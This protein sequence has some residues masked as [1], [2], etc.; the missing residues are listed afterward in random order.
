MELSELIRELVPS[1]TI[2]FFGAGSSLPS[3]APTPQKIIDHFSQ[4]FSIES[5]GFSLSEFSEIIEKR[6]GDRRRLITEL[7]SMFNGLRPTSGLLN[8]PLYD[9]KSI[10]TTNYDNLI[11]Q[12]YQRKGRSVGVFSSNFDFGNISRVADTRLYK[13][14]GTLDKDIAFGDASRIILTESDYQQALEFREHLFNALKGDLAEA[15]LV[16]IG[17]SLSDEGIKSLIRQ[18][19]QLNTKTYAGGRISL[20]MYKRDDVRADLYRGQGISVIFAGID[21]FFAEL[22]KK[23]PGPLFDYEPTDSII[24][25]FPKI[26]PT[27]IDIKHQI[28]TGISDVSRMFNGWPASYID[29]VKSLTF[30]RSVSRKIN[31]YILSNTGICVTIVGASG[32]GKT[33]AARQSIVAMAKHGYICWEHKEDFTLDPS[34]WFSV[35]QSLEATGRNGILF[36]DEAHVHIREINELVDKIVS[37]Q[38]RCLVLVL[39]STRNQ[40][41]PR[42]KTPNVYKNG[43][44]FVLSKIEIEEIDKLLLL[45]EENQELS[46]VVEKNFSGFSKAE[47]RRR[48]IDRCES[49]MFVCMRNI[50]ASESFDNIILRE[51]AE[52]S[53]TH[54]DVYR[55]VAALENAGVKVHRQLV[56]RL[57]NI[58]MNSIAALL[59]NMTDI[60]NEYTISSRQHIYG[61]RGRHPV[62]SSIIS[63]YKYSDLQ[64]IID[65]FDDFIGIAAPTY[66]I[67]VRSLVE[68]CSVNG[69]ISSIPDKAIQNRLLRRLI[70]LVPGQRVPRHRLIRNLI[71]MNA[72]DQA[73]TEIRIFEKDFKPDP[74]VARLKVELLVERAQESSGI[75]KEDRLVILEKAR[76]LALGGIQRH[77]N[78]TNIFAAYCNVGL[79][80]MRFGGGRT[81]FDDAMAKLR[82]AQDRLGDP[83]ISSI[84]RRY[85]RLEAN[86]MSQITDA[87]QEAELIGEID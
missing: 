31:E 26:I 32:V 34:A 62:I 1:R 15:H 41:K 36:V 17:S 11:E 60:I 59:E 70:S 37:A 86:F 85:E 43:K 77:S 55:L 35:A 12:S 4:R 24:E 69:G 40:W 54:Q 46:R 63:K 27:I 19:I 7:R 73:Q 51:F 6:T 8:V 23:S 18:A 14:H 9:W 48:L 47:R 25:Q 80:I 44:L 79:Q 2:L 16:I 81:C 10:Y 21:E 64:K 66:D 65:L 82:R 38:Y 87:D 61:W 57:L 30:Q 58:P 71:H 78:A 83:E 28:D 3:N 76:E 20:L 42:I 67:E 75:R 84:V 13:L 56:I 5:D 45:V 53:P 33:T 39:A 68:L 22:T 29:I 52:L 74:T 72:F 50:F 49:D